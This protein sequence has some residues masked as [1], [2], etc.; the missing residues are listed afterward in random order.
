MGVVL[1]AH[2]ITPGMPDPKEVKANS[3]MVNGA[4]ALLKRWERIIGS[5]VI[6]PERALEELNSDWTASQELADVLMRKYKLPF[7]VGHHFAS[8]VVDF[9]KAKDIKPLAFPYAEA[10]RIYADAVKGTSYSSD[11]PMSEAEFRSTLDPVAIVRNRVSRRPAAGRDGAHAEGG[12]AGAGAAKRMDRRAAARITTALAA[13]RQRFRQARGKRVPKSCAASGRSAQRKPQSR[14][15]ARVGGANPR[16]PSRFRNAR[17]LASA[18]TVTLCLWPRGRR[19]QHR[20]RALLHLDGA[21][22]RRR[23]VS[24]RQ[25]GGRLDATGEH[26][27]QAHRD[28]VDDLAAAGRAADHER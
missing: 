10:K 8:E 7:R 13:A 2:N 19:E 3:A 18:M 11:L 5:L 4:I 20:R 21:R 22:H 15:G 26:L 14:R 6:S 12:Q 27:D 24:A 9:A 23:D 17:P 28:V 16:A 1:E 25:R